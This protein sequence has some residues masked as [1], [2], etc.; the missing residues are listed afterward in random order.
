MYDVLWLWPPPSYIDQPRPQPQPQRQQKPASGVELYPL[1]SEPY[2]NVAGGAFASMSDF[3]STSD[4]GGHGGGP[5]SMCG[6]GSTSGGGG[7]SG[8][9]GYGQGFYF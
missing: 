5:S 4:S 6:F 1:P 3:A 7:G 9:F 2:G 8:K